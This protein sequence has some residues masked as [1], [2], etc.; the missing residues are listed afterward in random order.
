MAL[1][2]ILF[3]DDDNDDYILFSD[4]V[5]ELKPDA[6]VIYV[7]DSC[8]I[9]EFLKPPLP[10]IIFLDF[11]MPKID[12]MECLKKIRANKAFD[13]IPVIVYSVYYD[14]V[15]EAYKRGANY[16]IVKQLS[17]NK[18]KS[19]VSAMLNRN[20]Q[21]EETFKSFDVYFRDEEKI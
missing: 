8:D 4:I 20:W 6:K 21:D 2:R 9:E 13:K 10:D 18:V 12:G 15:A 3:V 19:S 7:Q 1:Y 11:N 5:K 14:R 16:F 17:I